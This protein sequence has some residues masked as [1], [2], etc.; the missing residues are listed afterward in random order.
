MPHVWTLHVWPAQWRGRRHPVGGQKVVRFSDEAPSATCG[1]SGQGESARGS[2]D[3]RD[4]EVANSWLGVAA[5]VDGGWSA[6]VAG[7]W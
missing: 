6:A 5:V 4:I 7:D 2:P 1:G 3:K